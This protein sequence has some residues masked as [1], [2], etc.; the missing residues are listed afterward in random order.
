MHD[1]PLVSIDKLVNWLGGPSYSDVLAKALEQW[2]PGTGTW[3]LELDEFSL[4]AN[5][6]KAIIW[7]MGLRKYS[8]FCAVTLRDPG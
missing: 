5:G 2:M 3:F 1:L 8:L 4:F 7:G 6:T